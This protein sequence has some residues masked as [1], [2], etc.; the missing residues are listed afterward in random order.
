MLKYETLANQAHE[1]T[2]GVDAH[3]VA[4]RKLVLAIVNGYAEYLGCD[5]ALMVR[6]P[7]NEDLYPVEEAVA[8]DANFPLVHGLDGYWYFGFRVILRKP[9]VLDFNFVSAVLGVNNIEG[10]PAV[11]LGTTDIRPSSIDAQ[12]LA[13]LFDDL[14]Q[15]SMALCAGPVHMPLRPIGFVR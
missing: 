5:S 4:C 12:G 7:I 13:S 11:R 1:F 8:F 2:R 14:Y 15:R 10:Q 6:I 9:M 3:E